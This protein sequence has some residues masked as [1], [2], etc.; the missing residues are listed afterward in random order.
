[1]IYRFTRQVACGLLCLDFGCPGSCCLSWE[2][3]S[4]FQEE[5]GHGKSR[6]LEMKDRYLEVSSVMGLPQLIQV[7]DEHDL[8]Y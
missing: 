1:M 5:A 6:Y 8:V 7:M 4:S 3:L 2:E